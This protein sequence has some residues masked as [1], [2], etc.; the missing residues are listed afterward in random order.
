MTVP[1][2][3]AAAS[4]IQGHARGLRPFDDELLT[5]RASELLILPDRDAHVRRNLARLLGRDAHAGVL[6]D[7]EARRAPVGRAAAVLEVSPF[8]AILVRRLERE[9]ASPERDAVALADARAPL[10]VEIRAVGARRPL[11]LAIDR[12]KAGIR[13]ASRES[14]ICCANMR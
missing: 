11:A 1:Y 6:V 5:C 10:R 4:L 2:F 3:V 9:A 14:S 12:K 8:A 7:L 13:W